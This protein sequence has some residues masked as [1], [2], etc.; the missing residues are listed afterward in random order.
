MAQGEVISADYFA[1]EEYIETK[2]TLSYDEIFKG[3]ALASLR[4]RDPQIYIRTT[5]FVLVIGLGVF[6]AVTQSI[7]FGLIIMALGGFYLFLLWGSPV[8]K[9][10]DMAKKMAKKQSF[11]TVKVHQTGMQIID[12]NAYYNLP[13]REL[14]AIDDG[15]LF[16]FIHMSDQMII[17]PQKYFGE[18]AV[19]VKD[20]AQS[21]L[22]DRY[23]IVTE[24]HK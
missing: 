24:E 1:D 4:K 18:K 17:I 14:R 13:F 15:E 12:G 6:F 22:R 5:V 7:L 11:Y 8:L 23:E 2:Y 21:R 3:L 10:K 20:I 19:M 9:C 16:V